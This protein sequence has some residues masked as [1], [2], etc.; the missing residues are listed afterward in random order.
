MIAITAR[1][2]NC[3]VVAAIPHAG[4]SSR[5]DE[6]VPP[7]GWLAT[8]RRLDHAHEILP[9]DRMLVACSIDCARVLVEGR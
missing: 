4:R 5:P 8:W 9:P 2:D 6:T 7:V 3:G 1:C